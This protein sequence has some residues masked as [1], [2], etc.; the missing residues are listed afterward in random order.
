MEVLEF[1]SCNSLSHLVAH[2]LRAQ[3]KAIPSASWARRLNSFPWELE[4]Y[5]RALDR[6]RGRG[7]GI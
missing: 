2:S 6:R 5:L 3:I 1:I 7:P 4:R